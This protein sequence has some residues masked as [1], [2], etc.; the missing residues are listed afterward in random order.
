MTIS[1]LK[2]ITTLILGKWELNQKIIPQ[3]REITV[4]VKLS[5]LVLK[6]VSTTSTVTETKLMYQNAND[7][8]TFY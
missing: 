5:I 4:K 2:G 3:L 8:E 7:N 6:E 1:Q